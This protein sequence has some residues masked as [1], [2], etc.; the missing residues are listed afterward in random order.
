MGSS[1]FGLEIGKSALQA[2]QQAMDITGHNI[3]NANTVGYTR[4][5]AKM[6]AKTV[7]LSGIFVPP[8]L[9]SVGSGVAVEEIQRLRD[10]FIDLQLRQESRI[11]S[12][13]STI[14]EGLNQVEIIFGDPQESGLSNIMNNFWNAWQELS[15][16][17]ES[18]ASRALLVETANLL[19]EAFQHT[20]SQLVLT[21]EQFDEQV[22]LKVNEINSYLEQIHSVNQQ[23]IRLSAAGGNINDYK[24]KL[25]LAVD[26]L[27]KIIDLQ[28]QEESNGTYTIILQGRVLASAKELNLLEA[29]V[30]P[31]S[32]FNQV[33]FQGTTQKIDFA[34]QSGELKAIFDLRDSLL[35]NYKSDLNFLARELIEEVNTLH[36]TGYTLQEPPAPGGVF[37]VGSTAEDIAVDPAISG[38]YRLVAASSTGAPGDGEVA[39]RI[40]QLRE[41]DFVNGANP[42]DYYR[43]VISR[44]GAER[45]EAQRIAENQSLLVDQL[46]MRKESVSGVSLDEE[47]T[48]LIKYQHAY[49]AAASLIR[50]LDEMLDT[51]VNRLR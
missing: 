40:A 32:G 22:A 27:S 39:L 16:T 46:N 11:E 8:Y 2:Q 24:D 7:P 41:S 42:D 21:Q 5:S 23:I 20:H 10:R 38:D 13:W 47:M 18:E 1:F 14:D 45:Q 28:V 30:D 26:G 31:L 6:T 17:P 37:F 44:L 25:D 12:Y 51:V 34:N 9:K 49:N 50:T 3:A 4:Q 36:Q 35:E 43:G 48:N 15:K 33:Y 19:A 29:Q